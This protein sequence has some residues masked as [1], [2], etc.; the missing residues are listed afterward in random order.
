MSKFD[1]IKIP[2][3]I[4]EVTKK[5]IKRGRDYKK[6]RKYTKI[7]IASIA[8]IMIGLGGIGVGIM[9]PSIA[10][11][12]PIVKKIIEYFSTGE[13]LYQS[14]KKEFEKLGVDL[15]LTTK[16]QG[17]EFILDSASL[18]DNY[19]TI[20]YTIKSEKNIKE[21]D[22]IHEDPDFANPYI[23][24]YIDGKDIIHLGQIESEAKFSSNN[25]LK[26]MQKIDVSYIKIDNNI[27]VEFKIDEIFGIKGN[28]SVTAKI[29][30]SK[31]TKDTYRYEIDEDFLFERVVKLQEKSINAKNNINIERVI[32]SPLANKIVINDKAE[33]TNIYLNT[34][35]GS[36]FALFDQNGKSLDVIDKG[37]SGPNPKTGI[38]TNST[39][40]LKADKDTKSLTLVPLG[41]DESIK[42]HE[43]EP[44]SID[45]LPI[46]FKTSMYGNVVLEDVQIADKEIRYTYYKDGVVP[47]TPHISFFDENK[48]EIIIN[49]G[50]TKTAIDRKTGKYTAIWSF[51]DS[52]GSKRAD[53]SKLKDIRYISSTADNTIKLLYNQ[54][55]KIDLIK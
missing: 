3:N 25:E 49:G 38:S 54:S 47:F 26:G 36:D 1:D 11:S 34:A 23:G 5:A 46:V 22:G 28:W 4:D 2:N 40:F 18:D 14:D 29:D 10:D 8:S 55:M 45:E 19:L 32:I 33:N 39:E 16:D 53:I 50:L 21:I 12:I 52:E 48:N 17:I 41:F 6:R 31:A 13:S 35:I 44:Q 30:K 27:Q 7:M 37:R 9:N 20:F 51:E 43:L 24:G 42:N 15:N